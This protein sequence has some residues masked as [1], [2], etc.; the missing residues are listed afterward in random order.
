MVSGHIPWELLEGLI[1]FVNQRSEARDLII[2][3]FT[4]IKSVK[5]YLSLLRAVKYSAQNENEHRSDEPF[6]VNLTLNS[7][8]LALM[9][10]F[11]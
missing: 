6:Q 2:L 7:P 5:E 4:F 8:S 10:I 11:Y 9:M 1:C 3:Q